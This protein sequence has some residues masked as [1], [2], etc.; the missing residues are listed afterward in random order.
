[1][2]PLRI[3]APTRCASVAAIE[4]AEDRELFK[5]AMLKIGLDVPR[6][7]YVRT[8][9]EARKAA[10]AFKPDAAHCLDLGVIDAI[11]PEPETGAHTDHEAAARLLGDALQESLE[12]LDGVPGDELRRQRRVRFRTI[13]AVPATR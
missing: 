8:L 3:K 6:S 2:R 4:K 10:A 12:L 7:A 9:D 11:V 5:Q 13:G 1:M